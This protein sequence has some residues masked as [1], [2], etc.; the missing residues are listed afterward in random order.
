[1]NTSAILLAA[2]LGKRMGDLTKDIPKPLLEVGGKP[3]LGHMSAFLD[4]VGINGRRIVISGWQHEKMAAAAPRI[5]PKFEIAFNPHFADTQTLTSAVVGFG[6]VPGNNVLVSSSDYVFS[7]RMAER[8][9]ANLETSAVYAS[10]DRAAAVEDVMKV[11]VATDGSLQDMSKTLTAYEAVYS[12]M[13]Y[14]TQET[15]DEAQKIIPEVWKRIGKKNATIETLLCALAERGIPLKVI[16][17]G[18]ADW[19]EVDTPE[20][21]MAARA[22]VGHG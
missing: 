11:K 16:D 21:L 1:M 8:V 3:L 13:C 15:V 19:F 17:I 4:W 18:P 5:D 14:L 2:G 7:R 10:F 22:A 20:E 9:C 6:A 12:G